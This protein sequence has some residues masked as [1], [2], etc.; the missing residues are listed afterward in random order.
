MSKLDHN[1][2]ASSTCLLF[3]LYAVEVINNRQNSCPDDGFAIVD[4]INKVRNYGMGSRSGRWRE[5]LAPNG[6]IASTVGPNL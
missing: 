1:F 5:P 2:S 3:F 4:R 6:H